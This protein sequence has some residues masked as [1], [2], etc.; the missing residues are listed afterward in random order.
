[1]STAVLLAPD[2]NGSVGFRMFRF[3]TT[4]QTE[5]G[6]KYGTYRTV[7]VTAQYKE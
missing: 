4:P 3:P 6:H 1:M 5:L 7:D 2:R